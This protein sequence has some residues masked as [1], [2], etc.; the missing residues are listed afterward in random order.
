LFPLAASYRVSVDKE[1]T[2]VSGDVHKDNVDAF[3]P[4][5][6][7]ALRDPAFAKEDFERLRDEA[8]SGIE[9]GLRFRSGEELGKAA[10]QERVYAG[11]PYGHIE[12]G[13]V[14]SLK[15]IT[16]D[17][18]KGFW[19]RHFTRDAVV[20]GSRRAYRA[21]RRAHAARSR[22]C[23]AWSR[24]VDPD[25]GQARKRRCVIVDNLSA[26]AA[27]P[28]W[29]CCSTRSRIEDFYALWMPRVV[30]STAAA[31]QPPLQ[32]IREERGINYGD[33]A[34]IQAFARRNAIETA[35]RR[36]TLADVRGVAA[37]DPTKLDD[38]TLFTLRGPARVEHPSRTA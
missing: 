26:S 8:I 31:A 32:V 28:A 4:L 19:S 5:L 18:V 11:T 17:D 36:R 34:Y 27:R 38:L 24:S 2:V 14:E 20:I 12:A 15:S 13:T 33:Y 6:V 3:Y 22:R 16:L 21:D 37:H 9:N 10:L 23:R 29:A 35:D 25:A 7:D 30:D 1:M